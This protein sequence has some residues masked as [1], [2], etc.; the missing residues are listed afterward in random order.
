[1]LAEHLLEQTQ[2]TR[3]CLSHQLSNQSC[4]SKG[5]GFESNAEYHFATW[6][7]AQ[8]FFPQK[9]LVVGGKEN[10]LGVPVELAA[11]CTHSNWWHSLIVTPDPLYAANMKSVVAFKTS[12][13]STSTTPT[14]FKRK[15]V[16]L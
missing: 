14:E 5:G 9:K 6:K 10:S 11:F 1:M 4:K 12:S 3:I 13:E 8:S 2:L 7:C 15:L 16:F